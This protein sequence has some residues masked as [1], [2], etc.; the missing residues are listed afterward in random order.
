MYKYSVDDSRIINR[1]HELNIIKQN[2]SNLSKKN[3]KSLKTIERL[4]VMGIPFVLTFV[5]RTKLS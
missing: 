4:C 5:E 3:Y 1:K 2:S